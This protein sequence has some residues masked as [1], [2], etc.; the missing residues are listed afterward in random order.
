MPSRWDQL[1]L[2]N[3]HRLLHLLSR[4]VERQLSQQTP[5]LLVSSLVSS[6]EVEHDLHG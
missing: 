2:A 4:L 3:R 1:P 6:K 5:L